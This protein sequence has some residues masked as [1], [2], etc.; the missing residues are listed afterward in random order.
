LL[1]VDD[2]LRFL[3]SLRKILESETDLTV[4][5]AA[6]TGRAAV[7][8]A[9]DFQPDVVLMDV[10]MPQ[11]NGVEATRQI[12]AQS[13]TVGVLMLT[14][15]QDPMVVFQAIKAGA[16][17]YV[18]KNAAPV[19]LVQAI[20]TVAAGG[21]LI[22][23]GLATLVLQEFQRC[24]SDE[25][26]NKI[27]KG[28]TSTTTSSVPLSEREAAILCRVAAGWSNKEIGRDLGLAN[29]TISNSL[30]VIFHKLQVSD[31]AQAAVYA[32]QQGLTEP[33]RQPQS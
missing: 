5:A 17:G 15:Y 4:V 31:R 18:L 6:T 16:R 23:P 32:V 10:A 28:T 27:P 9:A 25:I 33:Y 30:T 29:K 20:R 7:V 22:D 2:H 21:A 24:W 13:E 19:A 1:L 12:M 11:M 26:P 8:A 3:Q 14:V